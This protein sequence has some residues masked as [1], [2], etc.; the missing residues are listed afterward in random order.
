M[1]L[2]TEAMDERLR[3]IRKITK[4][5][6][7][8]A[9]KMQKNKRYK[10]LIEERTIGGVVFGKQLIIDPNFPKKII[11]GSDDYVRCGFRLQGC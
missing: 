1:S 8:G 4:L 5:P 7:I 10:T 2:P 6:V 9:G 11:A 3:Q